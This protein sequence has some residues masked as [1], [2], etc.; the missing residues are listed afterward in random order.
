LHPIAGV[1]ND[2]MILENELFAHM[3]LKK[4]RRVTA[5]KV[6]DTQPLDQICQDDAL[7]DSF[8]VPSSI[9]LVIGWMS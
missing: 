5:P 6:I 2:A 3:T 8:I 9:A 1:F 7:L 4:F